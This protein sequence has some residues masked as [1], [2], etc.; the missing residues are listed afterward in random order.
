MFIA[1]PQKE[2]D[3]YKWTVYF[4]HNNGSNNSSDL[5]L[6]T[7]T[8][9]NSCVREFKEVMI[10]RVILKSKTISIFFKDYSGNH[11]P[12]VLV[13][14]VLSLEFSKSYRETL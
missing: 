10:A 8:R 3:D 11:S 13:S 9:Y 14:F 2:L 4:K 5:G 1:S 7:V 12:C 6:K